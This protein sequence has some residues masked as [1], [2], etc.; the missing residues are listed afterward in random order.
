[1]A[2]PCKYQEAWH[3]L[4]NQPRGRGR[5]GIEIR[6]CVDDGDAANA[7]E[8]EKQSRVRAGR[9]TSRVRRMFRGLFQQGGLGGS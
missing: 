1:M 2:W 8:E 4:L 6:A 7:S 5:N 3:L 9:G